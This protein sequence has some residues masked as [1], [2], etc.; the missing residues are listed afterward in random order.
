[1]QGLALKPEEERR[2]KKG[3]KKLPPEKKKPSYFCDTCCPIMETM[4]WGLKSHLGN[5]SLVVERCRL[6]HPKTT[7]EP[8]RNR[9]VILDN[10]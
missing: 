8:M 2:K 1:M 6:C 7:V 9:L 4:P 3:K 5:Q 10:Y